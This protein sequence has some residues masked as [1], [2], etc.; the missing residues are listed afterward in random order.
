VSPQRPDENALK[1]FC[2]FP[3]YRGAFDSQHFASRMA[4]ALRDEK[5][6]GLTREKY[7]EDL[8][9][10]GTRGRGS[11]RLR[12][13][14]V[15][16]DGNRDQPAA[17]LESFAF[18]HLAV[19]EHMPSREGLATGFAHFAFGRV[20]KS[21][22]VFLHGRVNGDHCTSFSRRIPVIA[23]RSKPHIAAIRRPVGADSLP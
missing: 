2:G 12:G 6:R 22:R 4:A 15:F 5:G 20:R 13:V 23:S 19:G 14:A 11:L 3:E 17:R 21:K 8:L 7:T 18:R 9:P 10:G 16:A 1:F